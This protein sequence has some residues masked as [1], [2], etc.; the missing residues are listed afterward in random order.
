MKILITSYSSWFLSS[1]ASSN[2]RGD[3]RFPSRY[4]GGC[5]YRCMTGTLG[6]VGGYKIRFFIT[7]PLEIVML[8][9]G[10]PMYASVVTSHGRPNSKGCLSSLI[11]GLITI[12]STWYS[13]ELIE[14]DIYSKVPTG[15]TIDLS[16]SS[17]IVE[18]G[19][20]EV[21]PRILQVLVVI[22]LMASRKS[23]SVF[24]KKKLVSKPL[25]WG[26]LHLST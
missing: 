10:H 21:I 14:I 24:G 23:T 26:S 25:P 4:L 12:K 5:N 16:S 2:V 19:L 9:V 7:L 20:K 13:Q 15:L 8:H 6:L 17:N 18:V 1:R 22:I 3:H 11:L